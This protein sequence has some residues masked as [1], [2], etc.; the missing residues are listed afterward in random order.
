M[1]AHMDDLN[2]LQVDSHDMGEEAR[3]Y[4]TKAV[5]LKNY[6]WWKDCKMCVIYV[7]GILRSWTILSPPHFISLHITGGRIKFLSVKDAP[8]G[9]APCLWGCFGGR[10]VGDGYS[11]D[12]WGGGKIRRHLRGHV[13]W[14]GSG[15]MTLCASVMWGG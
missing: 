4:Y 11:A 3:E 8:G 10:V 15:G 12:M 9:V 1:L 6:F 2:Q 5:F 7:F 13:V 14:V